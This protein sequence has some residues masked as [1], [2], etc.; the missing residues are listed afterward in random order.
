[1]MTLD[2][3]NRYKSSLDSYLDVKVSNYTC[4]KT[5]YSKGKV[6]GLVSRDRFLITRE[7]VFLNQKLTLTVAKK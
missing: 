4:S 3:E 6:P 5:L 1:M 7:V 2:K